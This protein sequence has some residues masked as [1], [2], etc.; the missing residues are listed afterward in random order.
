[1]ITQRLKDQVSE[2]SDANL[3]LW[4]LTLADAYDG[5]NQKLHDLIILLTEE[6]IERERQAE[7]NLEREE[8]KYQTWKRGVQKSFG[9][10]LTWRDSA[11]R[12]FYA[13]FPGIS[14]SDAADRIYRY[15][16]K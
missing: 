9:G 6:Q 8:A 14:I 11:F 16:R 10:A 7:K 5:E 4:K 15:H 12:R 1:M 13:D 2:M 3:A